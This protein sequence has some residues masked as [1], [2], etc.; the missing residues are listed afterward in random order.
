MES[1]ILRCE[2]RETSDLGQSD[3]HG[4]SDQIRDGS[5]AMPV[6]ASE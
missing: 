1:V 6:H 3:A 5:G 2:I 4:V